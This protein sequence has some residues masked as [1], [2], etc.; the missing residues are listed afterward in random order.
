MRTLRLARS[1]LLFAVVAVCACRAPCDA[2]FDCGSTGYCE[3]G[4]C[5]FDC[6]IDSDCALAECE[7]T[8]SSCGPRGSVCNQARNR[9]ERPAPRQIDI[10][11][12]TVPV[13]SRFAVE[14]LD[15]PIGTGIALVIDRMAVAGRGIG[16]DLDGKCRT[17]GDCADNLLWQIGEEANPQIQSGLTGGTPILL[18]ELVGFTPNQ[19][20]EPNFGVR[21][22]TGIDVDRVPSNNFS[23]AGCCAFF[24]DERSLSHGQARGRAGAEAID[25][26]LT[27]KQPVDLRFPLAFGGGPFGEVTLRRARLSGWIGNAAVELR[28]G[29]LGGAIPIGSL[30][31]IRNP[32]CNVSSGL[33]PRPL[34][35]STLAD[36]AAQLYNPD[37]DLD[38]DGLERVELGTNSRIAR[39]IDG[40]GS[41]VEPVPGAG[42]DSCALQTAMA[43]GYSVTFE[44][45]AVGARILGSSL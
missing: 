15:D 11:T 43:D 45:H 6:E 14:G 4:L 27:T 44:V 41:L 20:Q 26:R 19:R 9:C 5:K 25:G 3:G 12:S 34:P 1:T 30:A 10:T 21:F 37:I 42:P 35:D 32:Y 16:F 24:A 2:D 7:A 28:T 31:S 33:C 29:A 23:G 17:P 22:Y 40:D 18:I 38:G 13:P 39:C 36:L 8:P